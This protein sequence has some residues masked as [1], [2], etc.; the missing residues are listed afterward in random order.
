MDNATIIKLFDKYEKSIKET[1]ELNGSA[2][3]ATMMS[4]VDLIHIMDANRNNR[5]G[6]CE[7]KIKVVLS[8]TSVPRWLHRNPRVSIAI[9]LV[10]FAGLFYGM[11]RINMPRTIENA[12]GVAIID[13]RTD[14]VERP[15]R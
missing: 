14:T 15:A 5:I 9:F 13:H 11:H 12:T 2:I 4:E 10:V 7:E 1:I 8:E 6:K 3:R